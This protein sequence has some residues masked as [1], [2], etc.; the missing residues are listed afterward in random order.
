MSNLELKNVM[1]SMEQQAVTAL[2]ARVMYLRWCE[3]KGFEPRPYPYADAGSTDYAHTAIEYLGY[4]DDA[5]EALRER[6]G[7]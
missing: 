6:V 5:I 1:D 7:Q 3:H 4:D 2:M